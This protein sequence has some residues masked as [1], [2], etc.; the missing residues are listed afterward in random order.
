MTSFRQIRANR[1]NAR[2]STG[3]K[4]EDGKN[5]SRRNAV[6]HGLT[7]ETVIGV[8][9]DAED[10]N[11]FE[12]AVTSDFDAQTTE[13]VLRLASLL[14]R[15][16]RA[17]AVETGMLQIQS[18][19]Q[20]QVRQ[21][22]SARSQDDGRLPET[23][24]HSNSPPANNPR[25]P[26]GGLRE[27]LMSTVQYNEREDSD[28]AAQP[29]QTYNAEIARCFLRLANL[30]GGAFERLNRYEAALWRQVGQILLTLK[31]LHRGSYPRSRR[32]SM[33]FR[34]FPPGIAGLLP[35]AGDHER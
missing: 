30:D 21:A 12:L 27:A 35:E 6:R 1:R 33:A 10:Y 8:L 20:R 28:C 13:L 18:E 25:D 32:S 3:P 31:F 5:R 9:E 11:A 14:W 16:R 34:P 15:L 26:L 7:A 2:K 23:V 22:P 19:I 29:Q 17:T 24:L 4:T